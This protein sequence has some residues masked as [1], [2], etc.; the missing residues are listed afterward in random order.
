[1]FIAFACAILQDGKIDFSEFVNDFV[2]YVFEPVVDERMQQHVTDIEINAALAG[3]TDEDHE[4]AAV[5]ARIAELQEKQ[6]QV[7]RVKE[8]A[9]SAGAAGSRVKEDARP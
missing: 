9:M 5:D 1:M 8:R 7:R 6:Q 4:Q 2:H 3:Q